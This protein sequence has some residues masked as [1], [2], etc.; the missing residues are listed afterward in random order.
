M[1]DCKVDVRIWHNSEAPEIEVDVRLSRSTRRVP[2]ASKTSRMNPKETCWKFQPEP[3][4]VCH[5][6]GEASGLPFS[7]TYVAMTFAPFGPAF[8]S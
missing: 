6:A 1:R 7:T 5:G 2:G 4:L 3:P 8:A